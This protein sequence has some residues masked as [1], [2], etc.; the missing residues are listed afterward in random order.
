MGPMDVTKA[1][2]L[3]NWKPTPWD[4]MIRDTVEFYETVMR[5]DNFTLQR[6]EIVQIVGTQ[7]YGKDVDPMYEALEKIYDID[8]KH[9]KIVKDEL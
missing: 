1:E 3:F 7:L 8:L 9:F 4:D 2:S 6:D 5:D